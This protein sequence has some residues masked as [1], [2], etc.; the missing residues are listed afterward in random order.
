MFLLARL[1][2]RKK[3][4]DEKEYKAFAQNKDTID[5]PGKQ[6]GCWQKGQD[7]R[8]LTAE[9]ICRIMIQ[10]SDTAYGYG[11]AGTSDPA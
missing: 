10:K 7:T 6:Q 9:V 8:I 5:R 11:F 3:F 4:V 2:G 1:L